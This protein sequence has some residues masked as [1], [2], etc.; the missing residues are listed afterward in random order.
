MNRVYSVDDYVAQ[1][2]QWMQ[3]RFKEV[4]QLISTFPEIKE[5]IRYNCP[6]Y[7]YKGMMLYM[8]TY[9]K[10]RMV[11]GFCNGKL[12]PDE[13]QV[14]SVDAGQTQIKHWEMFEHDTIDLELMGEYV[15]KAMQ[16]RDYLTERR[17]A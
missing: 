15:I 4:R 10:K 6:F 7:D 2:P 3:Q 14:L 1:L 16:L 13:A 17:N 9:K 5:T 12:I 8:G 11:L